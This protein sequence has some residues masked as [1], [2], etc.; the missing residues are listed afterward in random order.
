MCAL[1]RQVSDERPPD[2]WEAAIL[3]DGMLRSA[4]AGAGFPVVARRVVVRLGAFGVRGRAPGHALVHRAA[5][6]RAAGAGAA[7]AAAAA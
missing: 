3:T 1:P 4:S 6:F 5:A 2:A 7:R